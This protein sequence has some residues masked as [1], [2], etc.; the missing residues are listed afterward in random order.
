MSYRPITD[1]WMLARS[2]TKYY[3]AYPGGFLERARA[4]LGVG[5]ED[6]VLHVCS[7]RVRDYPYRRA[8]GPNDKTFDLSPETLPDFQGDVRKGLPPGPWA[9]VMA[10]PPYTLDDAA[11]YQCGAVVFPTPA[12]LLR[13]ALAVVRPGGRVGVLHYV[14]PRP[15][16]D[17]KLVASVAVIVGYENR[18]RVFSVF[19][20]P[21]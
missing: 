6:A 14:I 15:P 2:K 1:V 18:V 13:R 4:L 10:D 16:W 20:A 12:E 9:A 3:G 11:H 5:P 19:E 7:G 8:V 21:W 17:V